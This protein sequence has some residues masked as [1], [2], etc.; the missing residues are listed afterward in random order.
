MKKTFDA[1]DFVAILSGRII[2]AREERKRGYLSYHGAV[3]IFANPDT[4]GT[5][6]ESLEIG[7][8]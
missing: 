4:H 5:H 8:L 1:E 2:W 3:E 7:K 6:M